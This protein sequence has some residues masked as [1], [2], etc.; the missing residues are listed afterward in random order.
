M[1][2]YIFRKLAIRRMRGVEYV[3]RVSFNTGRWVSINKD[4]NQR[5]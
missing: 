4:T 1:V 5:C 2:G 3:P